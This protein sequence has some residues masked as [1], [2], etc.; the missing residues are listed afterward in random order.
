MIG[1]LRLCSVA[2]FAEIGMTLSLPYVTFDER[3]EEPSQAHAG[4]DMRACASF[5]LFPT[6]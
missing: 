6:E 4:F 1:S 2:F 5:P 3:D